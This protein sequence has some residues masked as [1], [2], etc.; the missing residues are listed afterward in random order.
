MPQLIAYARADQQGS[1]ESRYRLVE[2]K[3]AEEL[4]AALSETLGLKAMVAKR[5][6]L[7]FWQGVRLHL[8]E[9]EGLGSFLEFE[10][11]AATGS[12]LSAETRRVQS[13]RE[14]FQIRDGDL[15]AGSYCDL[16]LASR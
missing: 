14:A 12:D 4:I 10:A 7:F 9:V 15:L 5:R 1:R 13:L 11:V 3:Q 8:D 2:V 16:I 6:R